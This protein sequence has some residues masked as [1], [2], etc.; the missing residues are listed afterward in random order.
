M[1]NTIYVENEIKDHF[2]TLSILSK[3]KNS[4]IIFIDKY[5][6]IFN[7]KNQS[8]RVQKK[9]PAVILAKKNSNFVIQAPDGF[10]IGASKNYYFSHMY[11]CIYDCKYCFLQGLYSSA[12]YLIFVN[13]EDF[14]SEITNLI[15]KNKN[16][17][18]TFFS[19]YDCDS[20]AMEKITGFGDFFLNNYF[21]TKKITYEFRTKSLQIKPFLKNKP[22]E[23]IIVAYS[24]LPNDLAKKFDFK[25]PSINLRIKSLKKLTSLGWQ[26]GLRFD[27]LIY[28]KNWK[29]SYKNL[30]ITLLDE[31]NINY[32][33]SVSFGSLR[34]PKQIFNKI[35]NMY[36]GD[37]LFSNYFEK[38]D[39]V[40]SYKDEVE[41][42]MILYCKNLITK[43]VKKDI[44]IFSCNPY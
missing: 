7:R 33:H 12:N 15:N 34:F 14:L 4:R 37:E 30:I 28:E 31:V 1:I 32:I 22:S 2:R 35:T 38:R 29:I 24:L 42:E 23:N 3:F 41:K 13:Y 44:Q 40:F 8:F 19:G 16:K 9:D 21:K 39:N 26:I 5:S 6:E 36:P 25:A 17:S 18:I 20:L 43:N 27:P 10:G 11:N